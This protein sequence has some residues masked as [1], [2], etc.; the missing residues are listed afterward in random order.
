MERLQDVYYTTK[1]LD[2]NPEP[3]G[4]AAPIDFYQGEDIILE[5]Y[6]NYNGKPVVEHDWTVTGFIKKNKYA[7]T[8]LWEEIPTQGKP[9]GAFTFHIKADDSARFL[10][11]TYW[12]TVAIKEENGKGPWDLKMIIL[13]QPFSINQSAGSKYTQNQL[14]I[15]ST[16]RTYPPLV[17]PKSI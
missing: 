1:K 8:V 9:A 17:D 4:H 11:G 6:L 13:D 15:E 10:P 7:D 16:E 12:L 14:D 3:P 5:V 2:G